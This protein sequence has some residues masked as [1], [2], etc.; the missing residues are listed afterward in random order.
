MR[1]DIICDFYQMG[2]KL[3]QDRYPVVILWMVSYIILWS[4]EQCFG[5][6]PATST[7][8]NVNYFAVTSMGEDALCV[9]M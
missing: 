9:G 6:T 2:P 8:V 3:A 7:Y 5:A 1:K 4:G